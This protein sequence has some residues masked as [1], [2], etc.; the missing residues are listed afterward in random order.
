MGKPFVEELQRFPSTY[1]WA[2]GQDVSELQHFLNRW[3]GEHV[4]V[5]GSGGSFSA[6]VVIGLLREIGHHSVTTPVTPLEF[7]GLSRRLSPRT[8]LIS[9]E[10]KNK[11]IL[12]AAEIAASNDLTT[13]ALT[14][15]LE[16]P[17]SSA[18]GLTKTLRVF[19]YQAE[20][21][22]DGYLAT[23][24]LL[25]TAVLMYRAIF[26]D[27]KLESDI[28]VLFEPGRLAHRRSDILRSFDGAELRRRGV[29]LLY[30]AQAKSFAVDLESKLAESAL[31][32]VQI[33]DLRQFAHGRHLQLH[34]RE[35]APVVLIASSVVERTLAE[36]TRGLLPNH[37]SSQLLEVPGVN[38][39]VVAISG[40]IDAMYVT[41]AIALGAEH[42]PGVLIHQP[43]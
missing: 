20:W 42:D 22:K 28:S 17:L 27:S 1:L 35:S 37:I 6:A 16:T 19:P 39:E 31:A 21:V 43:N 32:A 25:A 40:L 18:A 2:A 11:D 15:T 9:A 13:A 33:C 8:L 24:S 29:L 12:H 41:E 36:A 5:V 30:S 4:A 38:E 3:K 14:L 23:N 26:G 34:L 10:G 7:P